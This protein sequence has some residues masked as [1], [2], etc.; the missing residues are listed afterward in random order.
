VSPGILGVSSL[1]QESGAFEVV[2]AE[3]GWG[4]RGVVLLEGTGR[5]PEAVPT[6]MNRNTVVG[7]ERCKGVEGQR[8]SSWLRSEFPHGISKVTMSD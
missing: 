3:G 4:A 7:L 5:E 8:Y 6:L 2:H 1:L